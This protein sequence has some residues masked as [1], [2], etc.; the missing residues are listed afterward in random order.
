[1]III[2]EKI[3][4]TL[5]RAREIIV[6]RDAASLLALAKEQ[7]DGGANFIDVNVGTGE[8]TR[9]DELSAMRWAV[10]TIQ[11]EV[12]VPLCIDSADPAVLD[13]GLSVAATR[14]CLINS[15]KGTASSLEAIVPLAK[16]YDTL[17]VGLAM[18]ET[19]IPKTV[20]GRVKACEAIA[21]ACEKHGVPVANL[22]F[23]PLV[24]PVSTDGGQGVCTL[25]TLR[26]IKRKF[27]QAK[28]TM[29]LSNI[30]FGLPLRPRVN[31]AFMH[32]AVAA[33]LDSALMNPMDT[34]MIAAIRTAE[35]L[36][37]RDRHC[38]QFIRAVKN[39]IVQ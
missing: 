21:A 39:G 33:G 10:E 2:G 7:A 14:P 26:E 18:D 29:G 37:N 31:Q 11:K 32:M 27:P 34:Q 20:E 4:A 17:L 8:G 15:T 36:T 30:S 22:F 5:K 9:E 24:V 19:G 35:A 3:N 6:N 28:T 1:M 16:K 12:S 13:A 23:D 38:R 25:E